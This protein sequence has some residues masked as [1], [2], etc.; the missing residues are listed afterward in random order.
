MKEIKLSGI[1]GAGKYT[2]VSDEDYEYLNQWKWNIGPP[3]PKQK[4]YVHRSIHITNT[5]CSALK[6]H[7]VIMNVTD[8]AIQIDH[9][10]GDPLNN[11]REN[12]R[13]ATHSQ[14]QANK[15][16]ARSNTTSQYKGVSKAQIRGWHVMCVKEGKIYTKHCKTEIDAALW[17]NEKAKELHGEFAYMN[18]ITEDDMRKNEEHKVMLNQ[19][20]RKIPIKRII[21]YNGEKRNV[22]EWSEILGIK[23]TTLYN[24]LNVGWDMEKII[25]KY[26][27]K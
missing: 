24:R 10:D 11:Q 20:K 21:E 14:N 13:I 8:P 3:K 16:K 17:Y 4:Q 26:K 5:K 25:K 12:L 15:K 7:R 23:R 19:A 1:H 9:I 22:T 27:N 18:E 6:I 2:K